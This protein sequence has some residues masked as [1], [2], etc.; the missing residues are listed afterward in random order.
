V[1]NKS[2]ISLAVRCVNILLGRSYHHV[3]QPI[4]RY[5][6]RHFVSG[7]YNDFTKKVNW[8]GQSDE[9]GVPINKL[10]NGKRVYF[11]ITIAQM[12]L[13]VYDIWLETGELQKKD[14]FLKLATWLMQNQ[15][16]EGGWSNPWSYLRPSTSSNYSAMAQGEAISV[17][18]RA[19]LL[20]D[21]ISFLDSAQRAFPLL[22]RP[23]EKGGCSFYKDE[24]LY[25][26]EYPEI[27]RNTVL[28]GWIYAIFGLYDL[29]LLRNDEVVNSILSRTL[30]TLE[31][32][33]GSYDSGYWSYY[34]VRGNIASPSYHS[35]HIALLEV[36]YA[37]TDVETFRDFSNSWKD[38]QKKI[39]NRNKA[40][41]VKLWQ[42][43]KNPGKVIIAE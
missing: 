17:L 40:I 21:N 42:K 33:L 15:D 5:F 38:Y 2:H 41:F 18:V 22:T 23:V 16:E 31:S 19:C 25:L 12:A 24:N 6:N 8:N 27:P 26:E 34:D 9:N 35:V 32:S 29:M 36:L 13:G 14:R 43:F 37:L 1:V 3:P 4:G 20:T 11:P 30:K 10:T 39:L 7:Y 28:N